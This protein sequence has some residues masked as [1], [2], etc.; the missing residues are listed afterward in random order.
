MSCYVMHKTNAGTWPNDQMQ[1]NQVMD[2][3]E[4]LYEPWTALPA[5]L[6]SPQYWKTTFFLVY[7][8]IIL[9]F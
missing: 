4:V 8:L 3:I 7:I 5:A 1:L 2:L 6:D 9:N